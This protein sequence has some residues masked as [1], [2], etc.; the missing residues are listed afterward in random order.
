MENQ[1]NCET[2]ETGETVKNNELQENKDLPNYVKHK[3]T[4]VKYFM[5]K[6]NNSKIP[7]HIWLLIIK[8]LHIA[9]PGF[10]L[11]IFVLGSFEISMFILLILQITLSLFLYL[12]GCFLTTIENKL[13]KNSTNIIDPYIY[14]IGDIPD[15]HNRNYYTL[16]MSGIFFAITGLIFYFRHYDY[17][18]L[19]YFKVI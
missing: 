1:E 5:D 7:H 16:Q 6:I 18:K 2:G 11:I 17:V 3:K 14:I 9:T 10:A 15:N 8:S 4:L 13:E 19:N 12:K